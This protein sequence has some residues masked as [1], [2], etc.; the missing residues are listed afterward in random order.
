MIVVIHDG[1]DALDMPYCRRD[2][3]F[4]L[5][6]IIAIKQIMLTV[7]LIVNDRF[8]MPQP[9]FEKGMFGHALVT[10]PIGI[11]APGYIGAGKIPFFCPAFFIDQGL[12][13]RT[14]CTGLG[15]EQAM[16]GTLC[17]NVLR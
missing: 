8:N 17:R 5:V 15:A 13:S 4:K 3:P 12:Q 2:T 6:I 11:T 7:I 16:S 14:I 10:G 9:F 1:L